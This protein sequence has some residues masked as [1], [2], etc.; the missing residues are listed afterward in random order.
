MHK[1][2]KTEQGASKM[3]HKVHLPKNTQHFF[4]IGK[5]KFLAILISFE[6][7]LINQEYADAA[8]SLKDEI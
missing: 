5:R 2:Y 1:V 6:I 4:L 7:V 8:G 3:L